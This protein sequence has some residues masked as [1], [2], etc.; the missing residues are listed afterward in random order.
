[1]TVDQGSVGGRDL[2]SRHTEPGG[3]YVHHL[4]ERKVVLVIENGGFGETFEVLGASDVVDVGVCDD[5]VFYGKSMTLQNGLNGRD[6]VARV[7]YD[8]LA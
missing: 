6:V 8:G 3:L 4:Y 7:D 2:R 1:L 5:D